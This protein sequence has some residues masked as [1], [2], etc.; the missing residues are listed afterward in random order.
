[1]NH[2][3]GIK[4]TAM[5]QLEYPFAQWL[6]RAEALKPA[7]HRWETPAAWLVEVHPDVAAWQNA[8]VRRLSPL[9][10]ALARMRFRKGDV[11]VA[12]F[13]ETAV[14]RLH[15]RLRAADNYGDSPAWLRLT[16]AELPAELLHRD[17]AYTG[18]LNPAWLPE[19]IIHVD[20]LPCE[21]RLPR[22]YSCR[23]LRIEVLGS[24][25]EIIFSEIS[26]TS[27]SSLPEALPASPPELPPQE[28]EIDRI[29]LRT[30]RNCMQTVREDGAKRDRR[31]WIGDL[32]IANLLVHCTNHRYD[33]IE[34]AL[35]L[36]AGTATDGDILGC[37][38]ERPT[39]RA[40]CR[41]H[42]Y[43]LLFSAVLEEYS[44]FTDHATGVGHALF[45][46][47]AEQFHRAAQRWFVGDL[48]RI[49]A[50]SW[51]FFIDHDSRLEKDAAFQALAV[52][53]L[54]A[55]LRLGAALGRPEEE[56]RP[57]REWRDRWSAAARLH[58]YD[59]A[60]GV[61][62]CH[63]QVSYASNAWM[64][65]AGILTPAEGQ[66]ALRKLEA[67]PEALRPRT[68]YL[69][70]TLMEACALCG[71]RARLQALLLECWGGM[72]RCGAD[73]CWEVYAPEEPFFS[74]YQDFRLN[75][76]CH[77]WSAGAA[78]F[79]RMGRPQQADDGRCF[80]KARSAAGLPETS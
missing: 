79:L 2:I 13:P 71:D 34:R 39:P 55:L 28:R 32:R 44:R 11:L 72:L 80:E 58:Y 61:A 30:I 16:P 74:P 73:V 8:A 3:D 49:P 50:G 22:R 7:L 18:V 23:Y 27:E 21:V 33:L 45:G 25:G 12:E 68:P 1:M 19:E 69:L 52:F 38:F 59:P 35:Y 15:F 10:A 43:A 24:P 14:G 62:V 4:K 47:A 40:G 42:D 77:V 53:S 57:L 36:L 70:F 9:P 66:T 6:E 26:I 29:C 78:W 48:A 46:I 75:S 67:M 54:Q 31:L 20:D 37:A 17:D 64:I 56:L 76:A 63:G 5:K 41:M 65:L 60:A 51:D